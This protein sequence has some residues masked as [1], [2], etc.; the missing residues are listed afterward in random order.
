VDLLNITVPGDP[1]P[2]GRPRAGGGR[3]YTPARTV[4]AEANV[5]AIALHAY[6]GE[7]WTGPVGIDVTF[8]F[9]TRR[10]TDGDNT[11]K[12]ITDALQCRRDGTRGVIAD[13]S[14]IEDWHCRIHRRAPGEEPRSQ[15]RLY[16][17]DDA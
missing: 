14:Q 3:I 4:A 9:A 13:D 2:K 15:I 6:R 10:R 11:L 5:R 1:V 16:T 7:P 8:Y 12:L 17:L